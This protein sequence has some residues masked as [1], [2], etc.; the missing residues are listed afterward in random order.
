MRER[1]GEGAAIQPLTKDA[2]RRCGAV[3]AS[4]GDALDR[5]DITFVLA[6]SM[7][8]ACVGIVLCLLIQRDARLAD[9]KVGD[10]IR[11]FE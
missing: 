3:R 8:H 7:Q 1:A 5:L 11:C 4:N 9:G 2:P 6:S 10:E